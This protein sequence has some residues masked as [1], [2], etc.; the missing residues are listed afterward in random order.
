MY[1]SGI[2]AHESARMYP[3]TAPTVALSGLTSVNNDRQ[4]MTPERATMNDAHKRRRRR[5]RSSRHARK[6]KADLGAGL[7]SGPE[8]PITTAVQGLYVT[9]WTQPTIHFINV[10]TFDSSASASS[11][12]SPASS[13]FLLCHLGIKHF[14]ISRGSVS[15]Y[16]S[17][18]R[19]C[20]RVRA[21]VL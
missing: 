4:M 1:R 9:S 8:P 5:R 18:P 15:K 2:V 16:T 19:L 10:E 3:P 6:S 11:A 12:S 20:G 7:G 21:C 17:N 13:S 14:S